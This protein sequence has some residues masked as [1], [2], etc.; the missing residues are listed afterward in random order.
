MRAGLLDIRGPFHSSVQR[1]PGQLPKAVAR[2]LSRGGVWQYMHAGISSLNSRNKLC[3]QPQDLI[4]AG[5]CHSDHLS[6]ARCALSVRNCDSS[7][8]D[9]AACQDCAALGRQLFDIAGR[10]LKTLFQM[11]REGATQVKRS[12]VTTT[13][14]FEKSVCGGH[15]QVAVIILLQS[16]AAS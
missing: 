1:H 8:S 13:Y 9:P 3:A 5:P 15:R 14:G 11:C 4:Q 12:I 7:S 2:S 6:F 16:F 10:S